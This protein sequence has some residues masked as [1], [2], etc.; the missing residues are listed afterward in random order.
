MF[1]GLCMKRLFLAAFGIIVILLIA[2]GWLAF[3]NASDETYEGMSIIPEEHEDIPIFGGLKPTR[4]HYV[5]QGNRLKEVYDYYLEELPKLGWEKEYL[6]SS[7]D[8]NDPENDWEGFDSRW[9]K[10]GFDGELIVNGSYQSDQ[11]AVMFDK[12]AIHQ[13][14]PWIKVVPES[15]CI[16]KNIHNQDCEV[17]KDQ[18]KIVKIVEMINS[19]IDWNEEVSLPEKESVIDFGDT[20]ISI[21]Y[22]KEKGVYFKS[23]EQLKFMKPEPEFFELTGL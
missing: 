19:S 3:V 10:K 13:T 14:T 15:I 18:A 22:D 6:H 21:F 5:M 1:K 16:Y 17:L 8:D 4:T 23:E 9:R 11:T 2:G 20:K 7:L 12:W